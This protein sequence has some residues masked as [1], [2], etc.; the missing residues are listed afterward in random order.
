[1][2]S[3]EEPR[4]SRA[5]RE[6]MPLLVFLIA[7]ALYPGMV[8]ASCCQLTRVLEEATATVQACE[9][10]GSGGCGNLLWEAPLAPGQ[11]IEVCPSGDLVV[12]LDSDPTSN[13]WEPPTTATCDGSE[14]DI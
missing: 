11:S 12:Y 7:I 6:A 8:A 10:D 3:G 2:F 1:M 5:L 13:A 14:V 9:P 4:H